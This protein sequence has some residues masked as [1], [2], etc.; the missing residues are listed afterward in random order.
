MKATDRIE[1]LSVLR[2]LN[3]ILVVM[4]HVQLV[5]MATG[6]NH[7]FCQ[8]IVKPFSPLRMPLFIFISGGLL[9]LSRISKEWPVRRLYRDK[10]ERI[11]TPFLFFVTFFF[12]F[13]AALTPFV[14]T[15]VDFSWPAFLRSF[16]FYYGNPSAP[17]WFLATLFTLMLLYPLFRWLCRNEVRMAVFLLFSIA[18]H[19][20]DFSAFWDYNYFNIIKLNIYL[21]YFFFGIY[22]FR[23]RLWTWFDSV[24]ALLG[25]VVVY[26]LCCFSPSSLA[27]SLS[28][29]L[30]MVSLS[31]QVAARWPKLFSSFRDYIYQ[32]YLMS[33]IFQPFVELILW[34]KLFYNEQL[35]LVFY[36]LNVVAGIYGPVLVSKLVEK[37]PV[38]FVRLCFGLS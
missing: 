16:V 36:V 32:I 18:V 4:Y 8:E 33:F 28:G 27:A 2:G 15:P 5:D 14:K 30:M 6:E 37:I 25:L 24:P 38:R 20:L 7:V 11:L 26:V 3:I 13:K 12:L 21:V 1:W 29:I 10:C 17:L 35:F 22:V 9:Y 19:H 31:M 34:K 23:Y